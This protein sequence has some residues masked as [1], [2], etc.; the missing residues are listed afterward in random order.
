VI[1][2]KFGT[3]YRVQ[4]TKYLATGWKGYFRVCDG[5]IVGEVMI[6]L[7]KHLWV[8]CR[9]RDAAISETVMHLL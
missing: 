3:S 2:V 6:L 4:L 8:Y 5:L 9:G 7:Q 1:E